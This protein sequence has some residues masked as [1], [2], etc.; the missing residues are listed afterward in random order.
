MSDVARSG[1]PA[2]ETRGHQ[3]PSG[4]W[5]C[6]L[7][8]RWATDSGSFHSGKR[9]CTVGIWAKLY[10]AGGDDVAHSSVAPSQ[11]LSP[12]ILPLVRVRMMFQMK[13]SIER[14]IRNAPTVD[15]RF[16][17]DTPRSGEYV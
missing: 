5:M 9:E 13:T 12:A 3:E 7:G 10:T 11:G 1:R 8:A 15:T 16:M 17:V 4:T 2:A 6:P 14:A